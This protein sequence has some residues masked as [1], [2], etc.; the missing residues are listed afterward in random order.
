MAVAHI[1]I[2]ILLLVHGLLLAPRVEKHW[3]VVCRG[4]IR[5]HA[6]MVTVHGF[7]V[8]DDRIDLLVKV[9]ASTT[10]ASNVLLLLR[11]LLL[12]LML[13][14]QGGNREHGLRCVVG[15]LDTGRGVC[16]YLARVQSRMLLMRRKYRMR[17]ECTRKLGLGSN[18]RK[19]S[20][21][22]SEPRCLLEQS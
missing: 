20:L 7:T 17:E 13:T 9:V 21:S 3:R 2:S 22:Q 16:V 5:G 14:E 19:L 12:L 4:C 15:T 11:L 8:D 1:I 10:F 18:I 6:K